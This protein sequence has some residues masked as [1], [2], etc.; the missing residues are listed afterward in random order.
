MESDDT[1][2]KLDGY[3]NITGMYNPFGNVITFP[4]YRH[5]DIWGRKLQYGITRKEFRTKTRFIQQLMTVHHEQTHLYQTMG[6][7]N[8]YFLYECL[9]V[10]FTSIFPACRKVK[11]ELPLSRFLSSALA[12]GDIR[13]QHRQSYYELIRGFY[14]KFLIDWN[15]GDHKRTLWPTELDPSISVLL[16]KRTIPFANEILDKALSITP[17]SLPQAFISTT[18]APYTMF[19]GSFSLM[20]AFAKSV[21]F[22]HL[23]WFNQKEAEIYINRFMNDARNLVYTLPLFLFN[24]EVANHYESLRFQLAVFRVICDI[25]LMYQDVLLNDGNIS[26]RKLTE[27]PYFA[28]QT[29]PGDTF[30]RALEAL[31]R[32]P[33]LHD[34]DKDL[35]RFY[36][37]VCEEM[38]IPNQKEMVE[39]GIKVISNRLNLFNDKGFIKL[40]ENYLRILK[41]RN[42]YPLFFINDLIYADKSQ[43]MSK[44]FDDFT[45]YI[46]SKRRGFLT[47]N[48]AS[49]DGL[50][51]ALIAD[52]LIQLLQDKEVSCNYER[53]FG[54]CRKKGKECFNTFPGEKVIS[55]KDCI[56]FHLI[57]PIYKNA[58]P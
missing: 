44:H 18:K 56:Y 8:G 37:N 39:R 58:M 52:I 43:E 36:D 21:E 23:M 57:K 11:Y 1:S 2:H 19:L 55:Q 4:Y 51:V 54:V 29:Q 9:M 6:T 49:F 53:L 16:V 20:E 7:L 22:E 3:S 14:Y 41:L 40:Q 26:T 35:L 5:Q 15:Q 50:T 45:Y 24:N 28:I 38:G 13:S 42:Q 30:L 32:V 25:A 33:N 34:H 46:D 17:K 10:A 12:G 31:K 48:Q 27:E 47:T